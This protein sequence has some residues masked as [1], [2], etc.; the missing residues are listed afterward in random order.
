MLSVFVA[1]Q[2]DEDKVDA[3]G[4]VG[5]SKHVD[6]H[7]LK[8]LQGLNKALQVFRGPTYAYHHALNDEAERR[9]QPPVHSQYVRITAGCGRHGQIGDGGLREV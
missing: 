7:Q 8:K 1:H 2:D 3:D 4:E 6:P 9:Q 5:E